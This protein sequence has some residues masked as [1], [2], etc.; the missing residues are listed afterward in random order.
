MALQFSAVT[1]AVGSK[2]VKF[3]AAGIPRE[4]EDLEGWTAFENFIG[5]LDTEAE[6]N[7]HGKVYLYGDGEVFKATP[8]EIAYF[9]MR[10]AADEDF[11]SGRC[12]NI[13]E[14][15]F[16]FQW[17]PEELFGREMKL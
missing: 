11:L 17:S 1:I 3:L 15:D 13:E 6:V 2:Q 9:T 16:T 4:F 10:N 5:E 12:K 7:V 14:V 8:E